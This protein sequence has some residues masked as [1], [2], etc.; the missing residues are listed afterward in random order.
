MLGVG[1]L[2]HSE[3]GQVQWEK[4]P[5]PS[6]TSTILGRWVALITPL[7]RLTLRMGSV[8][9][10]LFARPGSPVC[11]IFDKQMNWVG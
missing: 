8:A 6:V 9:K 2:Q 11:I 10:P 7:C 3:P 5:E 4:S 1:V